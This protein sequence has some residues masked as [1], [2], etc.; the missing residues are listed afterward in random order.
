[1]D[2]ANEL[3]TTQP[4]L[5]VYSAAQ[6]IN[7]GKY[8]DILNPKNN[9]VTINQILTGQYDSQFNA[10]KKAVPVYGKPY[11]IAWCRFK[12][13]N[14][15]KHQLYLQ[16]QNPTIAKLTLY[17]MHANG[18]YTKKTYGDAVKF[19][20]RDIKTNFFTL[21]LN[22]ATDSTRTFYLRM[23]VYL[24]SQ[25]PLKTGTLQAFMEAGHKRDVYIG[26][27]FGIMLAL[28]FYNLFIFI[29]VRDK[30]YLY[31]VLYALSICLLNAQFNG[32]AFNFLWSN[33][34]IINNYPAIIAAL[35]S[36]FAIYFVLFFLDIKQNAL[37]FYRIYQV[38]TSIFVFAILFSL[39]G[40][41]YESLTIVQISDFAGAIY[42]LITGIVMFLRGQKH[43][44]F[45]MLA[46]SFLLLSIIIFIFKDVSILP[47]NF[48][49][50]N[51]LILGTALEALLLSFAL[52][53]RINT[54]KLEKE[55]AQ[56]LAIQTLREKEH[57][58]LNQNKI[59][60][61]K[62][63]QRTEELEVTNR[64]IEKHREELQK[65]NE[66][67]D[68]LF[69]VI[70]HDLRSP[71]VSLYSFVEL[72][73]MKQLSPETTENVLLKLKE[74]L[75]NTNAMLDNVLYWALSQLDRLE[76]RISYTSVNSVTSEIFQLYKAASAQKNIQ[77][78]NEVPPHIFIRTDPEIMKLVLRNLISN[79]IK[80]TQQEG[81]VIVKA[82][83]NNDQLKIKVIDDG[84]GMNEKQMKQ[85]F[86]DNNKT[87]MPGTANEKG[88]GI[89]LAI[90]REYIR[91][92]NGNLS[93]DSEV[94]QGTTFIVSL[95]E[96][97]RTKITIEQD[98]ILKNTFTFACPVIF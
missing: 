1:M 57:I 59:L 6:T 28:A 73:Q 83:T 94:N 17:A 4:T 85:I 9:H 72:M 3:A 24:P 58:V 54:Y 84:I 41:K 80:Y 33:E 26:L 65:S 15:T 60:E 44:R 34:P 53:D 46:W 21:K 74:S 43:A 70:S 5:N 78:K 82:E 67:K 2:H 62:V 56:Q 18:S 45:Y 86:S 8:L 35:P 64:N 75:N 68:Q 40:F 11:Q 13:T 42:M 89:G 69:S 77:L 92:I 25:F 87:S 14:Q 76:I 71:L 88:T 91:K 27:Y 12:I 39:L 10:S 51:S 19:N 32:Y 20:Q 93:V 7:L 96:T 29:S 55:Q 79:A 63:R 16:I 48:L 37:I 36:L 22:I 98:R 90:C 61:E 38:M 52:A 81:Q 47:Y 31:Y 97:N 49:T 66:L 50:A 95:P 30:A 23:P